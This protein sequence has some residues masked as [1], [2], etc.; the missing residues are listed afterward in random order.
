MVGAERAELGRDPGAGLTRLDL[1]D[2]GE[3]EHDQAHAEGHDQR[4]HLEHA[5]A[6]AV[7][8]PGYPGRE[9]HDDDGRRE[10]HGPHQRRDDEPRP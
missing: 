2:V 6:D 10:T 1:P 8:Q 5:D 7:D 4:V 3:A 9:E